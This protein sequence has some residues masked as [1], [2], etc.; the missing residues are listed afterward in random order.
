MATEP[1]AANRTRTLCLTGPEST[2]KTTLAKALAEHLGAVLVPEMAREYLAREF[3]EGKLDYESSDLLE[4]ARRQMAAEAEARETT[5]GLIICDTDL[6]VI[7]VWW[8]EKY[9]ALPEELSQAMSAQSGRSYLLLRPDVDWVAD[10]QRENPLDRDRLFARYQT[11][12]AAGEH[13]YRTVA[14]R[15]A[16]RMARAMVAI[17]GLFPGL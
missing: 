6:L 5:D 15:G 10:P 12:L 7:Q 3:L 17:Q 4:I 9:G 11:I 8:E 1:V 14:G 13:P 16:E 2:G